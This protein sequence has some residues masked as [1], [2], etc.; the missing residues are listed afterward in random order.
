MIGNVKQKKKP[1]THETVCLQYEVK[2]EQCF[3]SI[4]TS[5]A[6]TDAANST[7]DSVD[8]V[9]SSTWDAVGHVCGTARDAT[10]HVFSPVH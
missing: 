3:L 7:P 5:N 8:Y 6:V 2:F 10:P 9:F 1:D 4:H